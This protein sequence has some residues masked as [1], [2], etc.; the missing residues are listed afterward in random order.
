MRIK[1]SAMTSIISGIIILC[2]CGVG[3][4]YFKPHNGQVHWHTKVP[5]LN[6]MIPVILVA[7]LAVAVSII[8][9]GIAGMT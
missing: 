1:E 6:S 5:V 7:G 4:W 8:I 2:A 9:A 3:I